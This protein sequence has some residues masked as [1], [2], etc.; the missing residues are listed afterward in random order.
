MKKVVY[1]L[2]LALAM[3][4][5][6]CNNGKESSKASS[7]N[8]S[9]GMVVISTSAAN[10]EAAAE[11]TVQDGNASTPGEAAQP[12]GNQANPAQP[13][14]APKAPFSAEDAVKYKDGIK[15]VKDYSDELNKCIEAKTSGKE[16]DKATIQ[17]IS[18]IQKQL[19]ELEKAGKMNQ[20]LIDLKK[21]S[22]DVY[23]KV[24]AK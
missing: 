4:L 21:V 6:A 14:P 15:L 10:E 16:I 12:N 1:I 5:A 22:D 7:D 18:E 2:T 24:M 13:S 17:R 11:A 9:D 3:S 20:Q 19:N 23:N 8:A